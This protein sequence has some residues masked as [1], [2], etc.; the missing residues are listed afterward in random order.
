MPML[1]RHLQTLEFDKILVRLEQHTSFSASSALVEALRPSTD[2]GEIRRAQDG[3]EEAKRL[4]EARPNSGV[5]GARDV[6]PHARRGAV[7]GSLPPSDLLEVAGTIA[8]GRS[9]KALLT[10][11]ELHAP[12]LARIA[13]GIADLDEL[14]ATIRRAI[15]DEGRVLDGASDRLRQ[16]RTELRAAYDRLMRRL[17]EMMTSQSLRDA[18]QEPIVTM[19]S[20]RYVL[21]VKAEYRGKVRGIVHDQSASGAT[22]FIEPLPIV[23]L[24]NAWRTRGI[25]EEREIERILQEISGQVGNA[26]YGLIDTVDALA[27]IDVAFAMGKLALDMDATR[28]A[29]HPFA[30]NQPREVAVRLR[31]ARHPLLHGD[32]VPISLEL[33]VDFD[34]LLI[35]GPNTGGKTVALKTVGLLALMAQAGLQIPANEGSELAIF[36]GVYADIGDEQSIEQSLSTFSS[37]ISRLVEILIHADRTSLVLL[38]E[39]GAG[40][41]PQEG[42]AL[43]RAVLDYLVASRVYTIATTHSSEL[44]SFAYA[45]ERVENASVEFDSETLRPTYRLAIG[46]PG[47]SNALAIAQR[48]G[49]PQPI[50][51]AARGSLHPTERQ[52]D[53][54]LA[55][56]YEQLSKARD[57]RS[58]AARERLEAE[59]ATQQLRGRLAALERDRANVL[60]HAQDEVNAT[61]AELQREATEL[62]RELRGM[63]SERERL[64]EIEDRI[65]QLRPAARA[66]GKRPAVTPDED[67]FNPSVGQEV[68]VPSLGA[69]GIIRSIQPNGETAEVDVGG[70]RVRV[71]R[72]ELTPAS[73]VMGTSPRKRATDA[74]YLAPPP[75]PAHD[76]AVLEG[77]APIESQIDLR[78]L[79]TEEARY[80]LDQ[81]LNDAYMEGLHAIRVVHGKGTGAVRQAVR[82]LL[83]DHPLVRSHEVAEQREGGEGATVVRLAS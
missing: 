59:R 1:E 39:I 44:K 21:P 2:E 60:G 64:T 31:G 34:T 12:S 9:M 57:E 25:E 10:R 14:E 82:D 15:D 6:R 48:L 27:R 40:T 65:A 16:I 70:M 33:G 45:T 58:A 61:V 63:R 26:Q 78:G 75:P 37:H 29:I 3:T 55:E 71:R 23:E 67:G 79:T 47:R 69:T 72:T 46:V 49:V 13:Q 11:Q 81:Y 5:R 35:T 19:R 22:L 74:G 68:G 54:I 50:I 20:G 30:R 41:D 80:K 8:A 77:W 51:D 83:H 42:A 73:E 28:P 56:I 53:E 32:V 18:L 17:N 24:T 4:V 62:R 43:S 52:A 66:P 76:R 36:T 7:G 38:D